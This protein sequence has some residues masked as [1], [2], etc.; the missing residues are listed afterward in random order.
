M[1]RAGVICAVAD[2]AKKQSYSLVS[3]GRSFCKVSFLFM[4]VAGG[5]GGQ[6][7]I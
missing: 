2:E 1:I 4:F 5:A 7:D 6:E 3:L